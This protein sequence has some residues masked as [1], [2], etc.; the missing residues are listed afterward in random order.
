MQDIELSKAVWDLKNFYQNITDPAIDSDIK[1]LCKLVANFTQYKKKVI[2]MDAGSLLVSVQEY[3][4]IEDL[5]SKIVSYAFLVR[6]ISIDNKVIANFYQNIVESITAEIS[7]LAF[8]PIEINEID[9]KWLEASFNQNKALAVYKNWFKETQKFKKH[10][11]SEIM[12]RYSAEK[13]VVDFHAWSNLFDEKSAALRFHYD[14]KDLNITEIF[15]YMQSSD[16]GIRRDVAMIIS[17]VFKENIDIF[18]TITNVLAKNHAIDN[19]FRKFSHPMSSRN[20]ANDLDDEVVDLLLDVV[21]ENYGELSHRYYALKAKILGKNKLDYWDRNAPYDSVDEYI[22]WPDAKKIV[23]QSYKDFSPDLA[24]IGEMFFKNNWID[25]RAHSSKMSGAF[26]HPT[27]PSM[28]PVILLNYQGKKRDVATLAHELGHGIHQV[29]SAK[30]G[31]LMSNASLAL[32]ETA[33]VFGEQLTFRAM[34]DA[35]KDKYKRTV[36][37]A[38]KIED[39]LNTVVRQVS[40]CDFEL[41]V[42]KKRISGELSLDDI[43][44]FWLKTQ[45]DS[46]G[47]AVKLAEDYKYYWCYVPHFIHSPFYVYSYAFGDCLVNAL[48]EQYRVGHNGFVDNYVKLLKAGRSENYKVLLEGFDL[49]P[50]ERSFW[51]LGLNVIKDFIDSFESDL[52]VLM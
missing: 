46:L 1:L 37:I 16:S 44:N 31:V 36:M 18:V 20:L 7:K 48:Y 23:L 39:M 41:A 34:L 38:G 9:C 6:S 11:F 5:S 2:E 14:D 24:D 51:H 13:S 35:E 40:F 47:N 43:C 10:Q 28:H 4:K 42:H 15:S 27:T 26:S 12:E 3:E 50:R 33:S 8:Y 30:N 52:D 17:K 32:A 25:A 19:S 49:N 29:L 22:P 21:H 45:R